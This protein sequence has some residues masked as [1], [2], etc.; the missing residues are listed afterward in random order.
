[1]NRAKKLIKLFLLIFSLF[2]FTNSFSQSVSINGSGAAPNASSILD[3]SDV[4]NKGL[5]IPNISLTGTTDNTT[6]SSPANGLMIYNTATT[7]DVTPG[8]Y[9]FNGSEWERL[10]NGSFSFENGITKTSSDAV[11]LGGTLLTDTK[12]NLDNYNFIL[13]LSTNGQFRVDNGA[14]NYMIFQND[15][16]LNLTYNI[17]SGEYYNF[18][19]TFGSTGYGFREKAGDLEYKKNTSSDWTAF[20][21]APPSGETMWWYKPD[22]TTYIRP[23]DNAN[24]RVYDDGETYGF[25]Y[26]G[27]SNQYGGYFVTSSAAS[28]TSA[29]VGFSDVLGNQTFGY[30]GYN[31][32]YDSGNGLTVEGSAVYGMVDDKNRTAIFGRTTKDANVAAIIGYSDQWTAGYF[33]SF[34]NAT[35]AHSGLYSQLI[36]PVTKSGNQVA[37]KGYS[38]YTEGTENRGYTI[39]GAFYGMGNTQDS[40]GL[41]T[42][43]YS[44]GTA[45]VS[46]GLRA[47]VD[48]AETVYGIQVLAGTDGITGADKCWG[49]YSKARTSDGN[50]ILG[51]GS[52]LS[53][54]VYSGNGDGI[55]G[56]SDNG[57]GVFGYFYDNTNSAANSFGI[58]GNSLTTANYFYHKETSTSDGQSTVKVYRESTGNAGT[59]YTYG[60]T[61]QAIL[62]INAT[63]ENYTFG[64]TG[65][66]GATATRTAGVFGKEYG[67]NYWGALG[68]YSSASNDYGGYFTSTGTGAGKNKKNKGIG[69]GS[70]GDLAGAWFKGNI[71]GTITKGERFAQYIDGK[72]YT[73]NLIVSLSDNGTSKKTVTYVPVS[74]N[75]EIYMHGTGRLTDGKAVINFDK[76]YLPIISDKTPV[77]VTVTPIGETAGLHLENMK[78]FGFSVAEN[79]KGKG[80]IPFTWI[81][82]AVRKGYENPENPEEILNPK[83]DKKLNDFMF[84]EN[85]TKNSGQPIW[86]DGKTI[87]YDTV[88]KKEPKLIKEN[89]KTLKSQKEYKTT[90]KRT[91]NKESLKK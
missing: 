53:N 60:N 16:N 30:L 48:S 1:M 75:P 20:P 14:A 49:I 50:A 77:I 32:T 29:V 44:K 51:L 35:S 5:L 67:Y 19:G 23:Q 91:Y 22:A 37:V 66:S 84:N 52:N 11:R 41:E 68:Y 24:I 47:E 17:S 69:L 4:N 9:Y 33:Y 25:Y 73:N 61:N 18:D 38:E 64:I 79:G 45:T 82:I 62:G 87:R 83:F 28:P 15:G 65:Y 74:I 7:A 81:A 54:I 36:V 10:A 89:T 43:S 90:K 85:N 13:D 80:N 3:M 26:N 70:Y 78:S 31:G 8:Y 59:A 27:S 55:I 86:W 39:G 21:D 2:F 76:K 40:E 88:P 56:G 58:L 71:Y 57:V 72:T 46:W 6:I 12:I 63:S 34:D 42:Y